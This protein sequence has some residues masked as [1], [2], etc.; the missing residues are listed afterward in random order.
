MS[1]WSKIKSLFSADP[2]SPASLPD[3][4]GA[5][6]RAVLVGLGNTDPHYYQGWNGACPGALLDARNMHRFAVTGGAVAAILTDRQATRQGC[7]DA[8]RKACQAASPGN[9]LILFYSGHGGQQADFNGDEADRLDETFCLW[10]G[11]ATDDLMESL[12]CT[13]PASMEVIL[14]TDCCHS[15]SAA[16]GAMPMVKEIESLSAK[17]KCPLV[18]IA[19]CSDADVSYGCYSGG[20]LT[21]ALLRSATPSMRV[22]HWGAYAAI[23][24]PANQTPVVTFY[25]TKPN[26]TFLEGPVWKQ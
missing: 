21:N 8:V 18:H 11:Q 4:S 5:L 7:V 9:R 22:K 19:G 12:L 17:F 3:F 15:G 23:Q 20:N 13:I 6:N 14:I 1:L 10:D 24:M 16:R 26:S 25:N 2:S